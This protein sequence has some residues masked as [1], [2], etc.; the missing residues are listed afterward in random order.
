MAALA[1]ELERLAGQRGWHWNEKDALRSKDDPFG[2]NQRRTSSGQ[3][4]RGASFRNPFRWFGSCTFS[5]VCAQF[6]LP[7]Q[8]TKC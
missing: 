5:E 8:V 1:A 3:T 4:I 6:S 2:S 7:P